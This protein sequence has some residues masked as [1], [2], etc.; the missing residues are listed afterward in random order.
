MTR[1]PCPFWLHQM[2]PPATAQHHT[3][4]KLPAL[5]S[6]KKFLRGSVPYYV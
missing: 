6:A 5:C 4:G 1:Q 2:Q 3:E